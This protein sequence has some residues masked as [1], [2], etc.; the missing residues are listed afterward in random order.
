MSMDGSSMLDRT[1]LDDVGVLIVDDDDFISE[2]L[3]EMLAGL[4]VGVI[5]RVRDGDAALVHL[6]QST[7]RPDLILCDLEMEGMDGIECMRH[8]AQRKFEG[9]V[10]VVS[11]S[12][13]QLLSSVRDLVVAH[14]LDLLGTL[15]KPVN[16]EELRHL[17]QLLRSRLVEGS[18]GAPSRGR[19]VGLSADALREGLARGAVDIVV[20]PKISLRDRSVV[21]VEALLRWRD[22]VHGILPPEQVVR[23]AEMAGLMD[24][25]TL[26]V[27]QLAVGNLSLWHNRGHD[28]TMAVNLSTKNLN[29]LDLPEILTSITTAAGLDPGQLVLEI[30]EGRLMENLTASLE[31]IGR[32]R[33]KGFGISIDDF[34]T[35]YSHLSTLRHLPITELKID[36]SF[37][38][39]AVDDEVG[40]VILSSSID[41]GH[42]LGVTVV[43]EG[44][45]NATEWELLRALGCDVAQGFHLAKGMPAAT[46]LA[47]KAWWDSTVHPEPAD[48]PVRRGSRSAH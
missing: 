23:T 17:V 2:I 44:L 12:S 20:Q 38:H 1:W 40:Q 43:A 11:A 31:V 8:L 41:L 9:A 19:S 28:L 4:G 36:R 5:Q 48:Q 42:A 18:E 33:L 21:G 35:G 15:A 6:D 34:G 29:S 3:T 45:E 14:D 47:W 10:A 46:F 13:A 26:S 27:F 39:G 22:P 25:L 16:P 30:T 7:R 37:L 24:A 32:L